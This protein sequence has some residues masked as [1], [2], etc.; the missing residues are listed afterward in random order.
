MA[1]SDTAAS[2]ATSLTWER[3]RKLFESYMKY[4]GF[5]RQD[6]N[7]KSSKTPMVSVYAGFSLIRLYASGY[8][9]TMLW[10]SR[11]VSG[12]FW[13]C[14]ISGTHVPLSDFVTICWQIENVVT[15]I[16]RHTLAQSMTSHFLFPQEA[17]QNTHTHTQKPNHLK[18]F[19]L[20]L[21][22]M[23]TRGYSHPETFILKATMV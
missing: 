17:R 7:R 1:I 10:S 3:N 8:W 2:T 9:K 11:A 21:T 16:H 14:T 22:Y 4:S 20:F 15:E 6:R 23:K 12:L 19:S 5:S 13:S 18:I